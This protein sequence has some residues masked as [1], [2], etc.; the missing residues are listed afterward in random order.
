MAHF[1]ELDEKNVVLR[2]IVVDN[3]K[4]LDNLGNE[5]EQAGI[6]YIHN[7]LGP[8]S[9]WVQTSYNGSFRVRFAGQGYTYDQNHDA[10]ITPKP[11]PSWTFSDNIL[12]WVPPVPYP[13]DGNRYA[14]DENTTSWAAWPD[15]TA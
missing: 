15:G 10:F 7:I 8:D 9:I 14:W 5:N 3:A 13:E 4:L 1:A 12:D 11:F 2:V 6:D